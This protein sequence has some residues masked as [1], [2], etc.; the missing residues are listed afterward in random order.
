[1]DPSSADVVAHDFPPFFKVYKDGRVERYKMFNNDGPSPAGDDPATGVRSKDV[2]ILPDTGVSARIWLPR[3]DDC[4]GRKL[5]VLVHY[6]GGGFCA[7]S[8]FDPIGQRFFTT[9][10]PKANVIAIDVDY[11]LGPENPLPT[12]HEDSSEALK[13]LASHSGG[14]GPEPWINEHA[15]L[16]RVFLIGESAGANIAHYVAV[17]AGSTGLTGLKIVGSIIAHPFFGG[18]EPDKMIM[19]MYPGSPGTDEDPLLNPA[20]D[21]DLPK[22]AGERVLVCVAENDWLMPRG[23]KYYETLRD[24]PWK[25]EVELDEAKGEDHCFHMFKRNERAEQLL[26]RM[27]DFINR[28]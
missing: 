18:K 11:R 19:F 22:M 26:Q 25:G 14:H 24:G 21:P 2:V 15:D 28:E 16:N 12:A 23:V 20:V 9:M 8:P 6:H 7:G 3:I 1:M 10:V 27:A 13:W 5:P 17:R 4:R